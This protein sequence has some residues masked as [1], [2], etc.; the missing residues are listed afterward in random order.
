METNRTASFPAARNV[1]MN[2]ALFVASAAIWTLLF[3]YGPT[4]SWI[5]S[6]A[7]LLLQTLPFSHLIASWIRSKRQ[8]RVGLTADSDM[9]HI[10]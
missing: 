9:Q 6:G 3:I 4:W 8:K 7:L 5:W 2:S 10:T 1:L